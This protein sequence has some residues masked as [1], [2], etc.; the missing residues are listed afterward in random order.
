M[1]D[2]NPPS[3]SKPMPAGIV[4]AIM[5]AG[6]SNSLIRSELGLLVGCVRA[7]LRILCAG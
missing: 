6:V 2:H 7:G 3:L 1:T 4:G 5:P